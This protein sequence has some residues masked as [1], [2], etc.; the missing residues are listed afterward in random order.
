MRRLLA[1]V[2]AAA[3]V[4]GSTSGFAR[5]G[6]HGSRVAHMRDPTTI[7]APA[8]PTATF[9]SRIPAP[10]P[11]PAQAPVINGPVS[12]PAFRGLNGIGQR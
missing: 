11:P 6:R 2:L 4:V 10:L 7:L 1:V 9:E 8:P 3:C 12:Q 5:D